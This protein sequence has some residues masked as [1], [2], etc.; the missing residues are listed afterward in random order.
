MN[1]TKNNYEDEIDLREIFKTIFEYKKYI[2]VFIFLIT[3]LSIIYVI[4]INPVPIYQGK[5][6]IEIGEIQNKNFQPTIIENASDLSYILNQMFVVEAKLPTK[7][8]IGNLV[9]Q[10]RLIEV[11]SENENIDKINETL[12]NL[13]NYII[14]KHKLDTQFYENVIMTKQIG[15]VK[16]EDE[17][18]NKPKKKL[19]VSV[20]FIS[21]LIISIF[22]VFLIDFIKKETKRDKTII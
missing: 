1:E 9:L 6:L 11:I 14:E 17:A 3:S 12:E 13:K 4:K 20:A 19:I 7:K 2:F 22:L 10:S 5:I 18:I 8:D 21:S 16:I 15:N